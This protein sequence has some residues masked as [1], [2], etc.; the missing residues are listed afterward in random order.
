[1]DSI[2]TNIG[3]KHVQ[4]K[5]NQKRHTNSINTGEKNYTDIQMDMRVHA[6]CDIII[7]QIDAQ[8]WIRVK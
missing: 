1:M 2:H 6:Y 7:H 8:R 5:S 4:T 3:K